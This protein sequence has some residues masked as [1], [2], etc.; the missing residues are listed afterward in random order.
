MKCVIKLATELSK[1]NHEKLFLKYYFFAI[2]FNLHI[3]CK[4]FYNV[5]RFSIYQNNY[6][7]W[8]IQ[9]D[10]VNIFMYFVFHFWG[11]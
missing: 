8:N 3:V 7:V 9:S 11:F 2:M 4:T 10:M 1:K 6:V 5:H